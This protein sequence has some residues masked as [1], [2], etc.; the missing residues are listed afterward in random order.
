VQLKTGPHLWY[1]QLK[2]LIKKRSIIFY[3]RSLLAVITLALPVVL[4]GLLAY[5]IPSSEILLNNK[6]EKTRGYGSL[7]LDLTRYGPQQLTYYINNPDI[8]NPFSQLMLKFYSYNN[9]PAV[10]L[11]K[12]NSSV[13][14]FVSQQYEQNINTMLSDYYVGLSLT[15]R[16]SPSQINSFEFMGYYSKMAYH[17]VCPNS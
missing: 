8:S 7:K 13:Y 4:Q 12:I 2:S 14:N 10:N 3:R 1:Q 11:N 5:F 17:S 16:S 9:R 15:V 6:E